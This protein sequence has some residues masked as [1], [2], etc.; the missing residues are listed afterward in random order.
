MTTRRLA[1]FAVALLGAI[2]ITGAIG[3]IGAVAST[4]GLS[5][6][7]LL[8]VLWLAA[9][10]GRGPAIAGSVAAFLLYDFFFVPPVG[11]FTVRGPAELL[12]LIVLLAVALVTSQLAASQR[13]AQATAQALAKD[14]R[15]LY[16]LATAMLRTHEVA[17]ALTLVCDSAQRLE[18]VERFAVASGDATQ[19][20]G[21][22]LTP[23]ELRQA[24][25]SYENGKAIGVAIKDG[26]VTAMKT[27]GAAGNTAYLPL[28]SGIA[29]MTLSAKHAEEGELRMLAA[30]IGLA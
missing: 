30:L 5:A 14:S 10:W 13:R 2:A 6:F 15:A 11:T 17:S 22:S 21:P 24:A 25:W 12:E 1:P 20:A 19:L 4:A 9:R 18:C 29:V 27:R 26:V 8:F 28:A 23:D 16:E 7:Y 3:A